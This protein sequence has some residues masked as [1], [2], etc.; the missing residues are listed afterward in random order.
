MPEPRP[1]GGSQ[2]VQTLTHSCLERRRGLPPPFLL[3]APGAADSL[4]G[5]GREAVRVRTPLRRCWA[6]E[7]RAPASTSSPLK[8]SPRPQ[9]PAGGGRVAF[10]LGSYLWRRGWASAPQNTW[11][12]GLLDQWAEDTVGPGTATLARGPG[13]DRPGRSLRTNPGPE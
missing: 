4:P 8:A 1:L 7:T 10:A 12:P 6:S 3:G 11:G 5:R 9:L 2:A 13:G